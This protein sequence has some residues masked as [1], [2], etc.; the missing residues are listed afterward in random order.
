MTLKG[1][2]DMNVKK[3]RIGRARAVLMLAATATAMCA[4]AFTGPAASADAEP[5]VTPEG[6]AGVLFNCATYASNQTLSRSQVLLRSQ[7]WIDA[8]VP[9]SQSACHTNQYGSYRTDC[10]GFVSMAWGL[11][12]SYTTSDIH[13]VSHTIPRS[14]LRPGDA[15]ND[16]GSH[17]ALFLRWEDAAHTRPVVREQAGPNGSPT[18]E[19]VWSEGTASQYTPIRYNN[20]VEN[21]ITG[22]SLS[23]DGRAEFASVQADGAVRAWYNAAGFAAMPWGG[24][25]AVIATGFAPATTKFADLD[26]DGKTDILPCSP[27][28]TSVPGATASASAPLRGAATTSSSPPASPTPPA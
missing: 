6:Q 2:T 25:N 7:S 8:R 20:I 24:D 3:E 21:S 1:N 22:S 12:V 27:T 11:R 10:S 9:Y 19:R 14:E 15:L 18:V 17:I 23:G 16:P 28:A 5:P 26:G 13:L 4:A